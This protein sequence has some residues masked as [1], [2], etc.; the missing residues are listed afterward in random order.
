MEINNE[1]L[2]PKKTI[3]KWN[4]IAFYVMLLNVTG[5]AVFYGKDAVAIV[6]RQAYFD[7]WK[8]LLPFC[9]NVLVF[10]IAALIYLFQRKWRQVA[11]TFLSG[12]ALLLSAGFRPIAVWGFIIS[13]ILFILFLAFRKRFLM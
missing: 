1:P 7:G 9:I 6:F 5:M 12:L 4:N 2:A 8:Y 11:Y 10:S 13:I 3:F